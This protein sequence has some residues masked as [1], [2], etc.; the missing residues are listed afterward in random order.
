VLTDIDVVIGD[1]VGAA[2]AN[3]QLPEGH[4]HLD[5]MINSCARQ[6]SDIAC[7]AACMD[8]CVITEAKLTRGTRRSSLEQLVEWTYNA[9]T[10]ITS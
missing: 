9:D 2:M 3:Q 7:H 10:V 8:A 6:R 5:R 1:A 4:Y